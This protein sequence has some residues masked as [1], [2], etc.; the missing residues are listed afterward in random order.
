MYNNSMNLK[1]LLPFKVFTDI[2]NVSSV[3]METSEGV[4]TAVQTSRI[5]YTFLTPLWGWGLTCTT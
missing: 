5:V 3:V 4:C 1:I 2:K